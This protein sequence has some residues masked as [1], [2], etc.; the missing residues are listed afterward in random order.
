MSFQCIC[1]LKL[2]Y[3]YNKTDGQLK[4]YIQFQALFSPKQIS[5]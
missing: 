1:V 5:K 4:M 2:F 3:E